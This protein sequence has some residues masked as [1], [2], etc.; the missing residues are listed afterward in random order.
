MGIN[1][2]ADMTD[3][4]KQMRMGLKRP[5]FGIGAQTVI[6]Q[7]NVSFIPEDNDFNLKQ[8]KCKKVYDFSNSSL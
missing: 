3:A 2:F 6:C 8:N 1:F 5:G 7:F 4:E